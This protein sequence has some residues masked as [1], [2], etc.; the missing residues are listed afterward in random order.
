MKPAILTH[1]KCLQNHYCN[2]SSYLEQKFKMVDSCIYPNHGTLF[3]PIWLPSIPNTPFPW[4][5]IWA[6]YSFSD[7]R[8][9][10]LV[11]SS[12][13]LD[14]ELCGSCSLY[15]LN[16]TPSIWGLEWRQKAGFTIW[17]GFRHCAEKNKHYSL[18]SYP[19]WTTKVAQRLL[20][21]IP[22]VAIFIN[23]H[24]D[25]RCVSSSPPYAGS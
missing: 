25:T 2:F 6:L 16:W 10:D 9:S 18:R 15:W 23:H 22:A 8:T 14:R 12:H 13:S 3:K 11:H 20:Q 21:R 1:S 17:G 24:A 19:W 7:G 4:C 5:S